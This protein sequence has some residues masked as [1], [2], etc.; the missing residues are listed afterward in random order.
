MHSFHLL[1]QSTPEI[2][3]ILDTVKEPGFSQWLV[4]LLVFMIIADRFKGWVLPA[5]IRRGA[6]GDDTP[7]SAPPTPSATREELESL[8]EDFDTFVQSNR[9]DHQAAI[10]AGQERVISLSQVMDRETGD[11]ESAIAQLRDTLGAKMDA[12]FAAL[13]LKIDP[14]IKASAAASALIDQIDKRLSRLEGQHTHEVRKLHSRI[15]EALRASLTAPRAAG[16]ES[17]K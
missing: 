15:D 8:K 14:L 2:T 3:G 12:A 1:S 7:P 11:L 16:H 5:A 9:A 10:A 17:K 6:S 4:Y 13:H